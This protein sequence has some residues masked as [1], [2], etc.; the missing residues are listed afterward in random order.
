MYT[1]YSPAELSFGQQISQLFNAHAASLTVEILH[2]YLKFNI[3]QTNV[4]HTTQGQLV[5]VQTDGS[6][7]LPTIDSQHEFKIYG[8]SLPNVLQSSTPRSH[9]Y[10]ETVDDLAIR[11]TENNSTETNDFPPWN[12]FIGGIESKA[13][14]LLLVRND[15]IS[16]R[17]YKELETVFACWNSKRRT[18]FETSS[19]RESILSKHLYFDGITPWHKG[20][21]KI[22]IKVDL[23]N[24]LP[25]YFRL[26][27]NFWKEFWPKLFYNWKEF[28]CSQSM[29][30]LQVLENEI[31][32]FLIRVKNVI[33]FDWTVSICEILLDC[34]PLW[35]DR[36][37]D[38]SKCRTFFDGISALQSLLLRRVIV[39]NFDNLI[40]GL[41]MTRLSIRLEEVLNNF[42]L[43]LG[44]RF[45]ELGKEIPRCE[46]RLFPNLFPANKTFEISSSIVLSSLQV[47]ISSRIQ[48]S[49]NQLQRLEELVGRV[50]LVTHDIDYIQILS[51]LE[52]YRKNLSS[53]Q[54]TQINEFLEI[55]YSDLCLQA[56]SKLEQIRMQL[57]AK[58]QT[59]IIAHIRE[60]TKDFEDAFNKLN[61]SD[62]FE[63]IQFLA[64]TREFDLPL[65][66][67]KIIDFLS[68]LAKHFDYLED[69]MFVRCYQVSRYPH[70]LEMV[71]KLV[72]K[73]LETELETISKK[74]LDRAN[75]FCFEINII[76]REFKSTLKKYMNAQTITQ[77]LQFSNR[78]ADLE[79]KIHPMSQLY[80]ILNSQLNLL[81]METLTVEIAGLQEQIEKLNKLSS[82]HKEVVLLEEKF[83][84]AKVC[85]IDLDE[86][87]DQFVR[88]N[89][90]FG[91][92]KSDLAFNDAEQDAAELWQEI[93][94]KMEEIDKAYTEFMPILKEIC[95]ENFRDH[96]WANILKGTNLSKDTLLVKDLSSQ[97]F[98][99]RIQTYTEISA[100]V[101]KET[102]VEEIMNEIQEFWANQFIQFLPQLEGAKLIIEPNI[103]SKIEEHLVKIQ[104]TMTSTFVGPL[105]NRL[106]DWLVKLQRLKT[107]LQHYKKCQAKWNYVEPLFQA[108]EI[109]YQIPD[110]WR[111]FKK[112]TETWTSINKKLIAAEKVVNIESTNVGEEFSSVSEMLDKIRLGFDAYLQKKRSNWPRLYFLTNEELLD[113]FSSAKNSKQIL[114]FLPRLFT[115][116]VDVELNSRGEIVGLING[117]NETLP[118]VKTINPA[119]MKRHIDKWLHELERQMRASVHQQINQLIT[120][121]KLELVGLNEI[122]ATSYSAQSILLYYQICFANKIEHGLRDR[123]AG[124]LLNEFE[125]FQENCKKYVPKSTRESKIKDSLL[126]EAKRF[127]TKLHRIYELKG[128]NEHVDWLQEL[129]YYWQNENVHIRF[130]NSSIPFSYEFLDVD[131]IFLSNSYLQHAFRLLLTINPINSLTLLYGSKQISSE[132]IKHLANALEE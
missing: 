19:N 31:E 12:G 96:H 112:L 71:I 6:L 131:S 1:D 25:I 47:E 66:R 98:L 32:I 15:D 109:A 90:E 48:E 130:F 85:E 87:S 34:S 58:I 2:S 79:E 118:L 103:M 88:V 55:N 52:P 81:G 111:L 80:T 41:T 51:D 106:N 8:R 40:K 36:L 5:H 84:F 46:S 49:Y 124:S 110:E 100:I 123:Y 29:I 59:V 69:N 63:Q 76:E 27:G 82:S 73:K 78:F 97:D 108:E 17:L 132:I 62:P 126:I 95:N 117:S 104:M 113:L 65:M 4:T 26:A 14:D 43:R 74:V 68:K 107:C 53:T 54:T 18:S 119:L 21:M 129:R 101:S 120:E 77:L 115:S 39:E 94:S 102:E 83:L 70:K 89:R 75:M 44:D 121:R 13:S 50:D 60:T 92:T 35:I 11:T 38:E 67:A 61:T 127:Y 9:R 57:I 93:C 45:K 125:K 86:V 105:N 37:S 64:K 33:K 114:T 56:A 22:G 24:T 16:I 91:T 20:V 128:S 99:K 122:L 23:E 28:L 30:S 7:V 3:K 10:F 72:W 116:V 42:T